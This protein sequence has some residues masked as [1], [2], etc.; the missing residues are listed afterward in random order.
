MKR[1]VFL[2]LASFMFFTLAS[3][4]EKAEASD[5]ADM[6]NDTVVPYN[7]QM[8]GEMPDDEY[9][10]AEWYGFVSKE[11]SKDRRRA[12]TWKEYCTMIGTMIS[13]KDTELGT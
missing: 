2:M 12:V 9:E 5:T 7:E 11:L 8:T 4:G 3:N 10:R 6:V 1:T 13:L